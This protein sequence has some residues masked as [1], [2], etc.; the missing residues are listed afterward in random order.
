MRVRGT[1]L[2]AGCVLLLAGQAQAVCKLS[3]LAELPVTLADQRAVVVAQINGADAPFIVD[4]GAFWSSISPASA[5]QYKLRLHNAPPEL[6]VSGIGG[7]VQI[8]V[9]TVDEFK[10]VR[11]PFRH[12]DFMVGGGEVGS[13]AVGVIGQN[14]LRMAD[15]EYDL[16]NGVIRLVRTEDCGKSAL[17]YWAGSADFS[18]LSLEWPTVQAPFTRG[19]AYL[20]GAR[21]RVLFDSGASNSMLSL[22]AA[23]RAGVK[24]DGPDVMPAG[25][26]R[27]IGRRVITTYIAPFASFKIGGEEIRRTRLRIGDLG[28]VDAD[29]LIGA[30]FFL[31]HRIYV[32]STQHRLYFTYNGGPVFNLTAAATQPAKGVETAPAPD[33]GGAGEAEERMDAAAYARRGT[34]AAGRR[35]FEHAVAD[36]T[37]AMQM[38]PANSAF[39]YERATAYLESGH[40][41]EAMPDVDLAL[42]LKPDDVP[43]LVMRAELRLSSRDSGRRDQEA[44]VADL[45]AADRTAPKEADIRLRLGELYARAGLGPRALPLYD[46]WISAHAADSRLPRALTDRCTLRTNEGLDPDKALDDCNRALKLSPKTAPIL[47]A[48]GFAR[49]RQAKYADSI[50][51]FDAALELYPR[52]AWCLYARGLAK[53]H[54]GSPA[55]A[56]ADIDAATALQPDIAELAAKRGFVR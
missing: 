29:M 6:R 35:D 50:K 34:A 39:A 44:V 32:S 31:S 9:A 2:L 14:I 4:S 18:D 48:R 8:S 11:V 10:L 30:D 15:I 54:K 22:R 41:A 36:L 19:D 51:D 33:A 53:Q 16:A 26:S 52:N 27:G 5:A 42:K 25:M 49:L 23:A 21:I 38:D 56:Q 24:T 55:E 12:I 20:N 7:S 17:A 43:A 3:K 47:E 28:D 46:Q 13:G 45:D 37:H 40:P 1:R